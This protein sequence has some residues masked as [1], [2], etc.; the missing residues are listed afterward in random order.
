MPTAVHEY[1]ISEFSKRVQVALDSL[2]IN[3]ERLRVGVE[4]GLSIRSP[5][6]DFL[7]TPDLALVAALSGDRSSVF[8]V[9][10]C[11]F[12]QDHAKMM[13]KIRD[14]VEGWPEITLAL[15]IFISEVRDYKSPLPGSPTWDYFAQRK[16]NHPFLKFL[17]LPSSV[18]GSTASTPVEHTPADADDLD[19]HSD[20]S[21]SPNLNSHVDLD[22]RP[23]TIAG[24]T[25]CEIENVKF[26]VWVKENG[27][28]D[29]DEDSVTGVSGH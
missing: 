26:R 28:L 29:L 20:T 4:R 18:N 23:V 17:S 1:T 15:A 3:I 9:M 25:W 5:L 13:M 10:E 16:A 7:A 12:S 19:G 24:H 11:A 27:V 21:D 2:P 22:L 14:E 6:T 8:G